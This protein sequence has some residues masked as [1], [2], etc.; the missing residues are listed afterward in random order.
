MRHDVL[1]VILASALLQAAANLLL[2]AGL[3][4]AG[5][6]HIDVSLLYQLG[7]LL[8]QPLFAYGVFLY[9]VA[10]IVWFSVLSLDNLSS[11]YPL[12]VGATFIF[13]ALGA[14]CF[15][16]ETVSLLK[17]IGMLTIVA[18]IALVTVAR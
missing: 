13:V 17:A 9:A 2:R 3:L 10:A 5:G 14:I 6:L 15:L 16:Q 7:R 11:S 18:G 12:L 4:A 1:M 8:L